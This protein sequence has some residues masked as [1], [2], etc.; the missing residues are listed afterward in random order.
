MSVYLIL[1]D[2]DK[3]LIFV[4]KKEGGAMHYSSCY[5]FCLSRLVAVQIYHASLNT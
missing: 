3:D 5:Q 1:L 4:T 2:K